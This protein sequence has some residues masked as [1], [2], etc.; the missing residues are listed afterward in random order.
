[1]FS[2]NHL[3]SIAF[4]VPS[5]FKA[6]IDQVVRIGHTFAYADGQFSGLVTGKRALVTLSYGAAGYAQGG[7]LETYDFM[8][9]YVNM[10][11]NFIGIS[12]VTFFAIE[13]TTADPETI[14]TNRTTAKGAIDQFI[15]AQEAA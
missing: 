7:P 12:D 13:A 3:A 1:M 8:R 9:P 6:W 4:S 2:V 11:L 5:A 10:I 14:A 15:A